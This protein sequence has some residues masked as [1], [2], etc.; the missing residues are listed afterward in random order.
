MAEIKKHTHKAALAVFR[1]NCRKYKNPSNKDIEPSRSGLNIDLMPAPLRL[2]V[3]GKKAHNPTPE[4]RYKKRLSE[5]YVYSRADVKT[6]CSC[7]ITKPMGL[8]PEQEIPFF[9]E[10]YKFLAAR[11]GENNIVQAVVHMDET[12]PHV[13]VCFI[14]AVP[15]KKRGGEKVCASEAITREELRAFHPALQEHLKMAGIQARVQTGI[16]KKQGGNRRVDQLKRDR[17]E[18]TYER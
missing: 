15:D 1:H 6:V 14:P 5:L 2:N 9:R 11:Y 18:V 12:S 13:H 10:C 7:L 8:Q 4:E 3:S 17:K 16:T